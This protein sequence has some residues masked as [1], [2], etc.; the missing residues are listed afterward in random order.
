M[1]TYMRL[2]CSLFFVCIDFVLVMN[3]F[4]WG[5]LI[6]GVAPTLKEECPA[7][8]QRFTISQITRPYYCDHQKFHVT[9]IVMSTTP[10]GIQHT[11]KEEKTFRGS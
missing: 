4:I 5:V 8:T 11:L 3:F 2:L 9:M 6:R 7:P 1:Y 10:I